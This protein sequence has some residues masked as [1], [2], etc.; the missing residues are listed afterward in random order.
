MRLPP[1]E[2]L[3]A[4][5]RLSRSGSQPL[6]N[7]ALERAPL[8][9]GTAPQRGMRQD[10]GA[11]VGEALLEIVVLEAFVAGPHVYPEP[12]GAFVGGTTAGPVQQLGTEALAAVG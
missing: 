11:D 10:N 8:G 9:A 7:A 4:R 1:R 2:L 6:A 3:A 12:V 5:P